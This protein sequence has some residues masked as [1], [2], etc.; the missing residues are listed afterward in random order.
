MECEQNLGEIP[1]DHQTWPAG[2][3]PTS[4]LPCVGYVSTAM[5]ATA[6][7]NQWE[8]LKSYT[9]YGCLNLLK[10]CWGWGLGMGMGGLIFL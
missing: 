10:E 2:K 9:S 4:K 7:G 1:S 6:P 8:T 3:I 5:L